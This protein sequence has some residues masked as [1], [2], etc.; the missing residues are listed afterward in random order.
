MRHIACSAVFVQINAEAAP[1]SLAGL[2]MHWV[3][4]AMRVRT[5]CGEAYITVC[6]CMRWQ[7]PVQSRGRQPTN[8]MPALHVCPR[9]RPTCGVTQFPAGCW[10]WPRQHHVLCLG[11]GWHTPCVRPA[12]LPGG[13]QCVLLLQPKI[14]RYLTPA[15]GCIAAGPGPFF[16]IPDSGIEISRGFA[17]DQ[18][19]AF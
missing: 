1:V 3:T 8:A 9:P 11:W 2:A 15:G 6:A 13:P 18:T 7:P 12:Y 5:A 10:S 4:H 17:T 19:N 16:W 14:A